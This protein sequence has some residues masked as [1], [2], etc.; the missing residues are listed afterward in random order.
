MLKA[1][2]ALEETRRIRKSFVRLVRK[3]LRLRTALARLCTADPKPYKI[4]EN[5]LKKAYFCL[6]LASSLKNA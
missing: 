4:I 2:V 6:P 3:S 5:G 1:S